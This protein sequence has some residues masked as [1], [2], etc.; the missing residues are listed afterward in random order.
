[1]Q[2]H[3]AAANHNSEQK[4]SLKGRAGEKIKERGGEKVMG[5]GGGSCLA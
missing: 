5:H 3:K 2:K 4:Q 1:M